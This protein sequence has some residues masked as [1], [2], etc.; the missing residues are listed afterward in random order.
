MIITVNGELR[1]LDGGRS[2][3]SAIYSRNPKI[4]RKAMYNFFKAMRERGWHSNGNIREPMPEFRI[5]PYMK[6]DQMY[7]QLQTMMASMQTGIENIG[8]PDPYKPERDFW[9]HEATH[10]IIYVD[11]L[12]AA[13][14]LWPVN[15]VL[16]LVDGTNP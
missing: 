15:E 14:K 9:Q 6:P 11:E 7:E 16:E 5:R 13:A 4:R 12:L 3:E 2:F 1:I 8:K 10:Q